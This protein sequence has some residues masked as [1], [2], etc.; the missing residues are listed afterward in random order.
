M[1]RL[2]DQDR[3]AMMRQA[4]AAERRNSPRMLVV[5]AVIVLLVAGVYAGLGWMGRQSSLRSLRSAQF[6]Q[7]RVQ[8]QLDELR[9][10]RSPEASQGGVQVWDRLVSPVA[11]LER[12]AQNA[13]F[14]DP[15]YD[16]ERSESDTGETHRRI[17]RF[18]EIRGVS[19][20]DV[21][22]WANAVERD[23]D[24]MRVYSMDFRAPAN[25]RGW[26]VTVQF[27]RLE[28]KQ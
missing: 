20:V 6:S 28:K 8:A 10:L 4:G 15:N 19:A 1:T 14:P 21:L 17:F 13:E 18:K 7:D 16:S 5:L 22:R 24:G 11:L 2:S 9:R 25:K 12:A 23:I 3:L 26:D 27:S